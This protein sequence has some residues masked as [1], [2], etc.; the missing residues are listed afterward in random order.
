MTDVA[1]LARAPCSEAQH[2]PN[3][4]SRRIEREI[5]AIGARIE[6]GS[7]DVTLPTGRR[8]HFGVGEPHAE[9]TLHGWGALSALAARGDIGWGEA[10]IAGLWDSPDIEALARVTLLNG[11]AF[12][13]PLRPN[14]INQAVFRLTDRL[15]RRNSRAG[16]ARNIR[17]HYDVGDAFYRLWLDPTMTYSAALFRDGADSL[18]AAQKAKYRRLLDATADAGPRTLEIGCGWGGFAEAAAAAGREVTAIT[19]SKAQ[20]AYARKRLGDD[21][22]IVLSDYRDIGGTYDSIVSI[23]MIEAVGERYWPV[24]FQTVKQRLAAGGRAAIQAIIVDDLHFETYRR[25]SDFI[26]QY[27]F[28]GGMLLSPAALERA[29][30]GAGLKMENLHRFGGDYARTLRQ[31]QADFEAALPE[32]KA[33]GYDDGFIRGWRYYLAI[34]AATFALGRTDVAHVEFVHA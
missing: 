25:R 19:I 20:H 23:E 3:R 8:L 30:R 4:L 9:L 7:I 1:S 26:R 16:S 17:A 27:I 33:L 5:A 11:A 12:E 29:A 13:K 34:C 10:Y 15:I 22:R 28:P 18:E 21:A 31:W 14:R 24:Y 2:Q 6:R 32:I